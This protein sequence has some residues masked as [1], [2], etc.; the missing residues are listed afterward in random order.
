MPELPEVEIVRRTLSPLLGQRMM[1]VSVSGP[2]VIRGL[3]AEAF[4]AQLVGRQVDS[5]ERRGK[6]LLIGLTPK[7][8]VLVHLRMTGRLRLADATAPLERHTHVRIALESGGELRYTDQ[9]RFGGFWVVGEGTVPEGFRT[10]GPE[11][12]SGDLAA[13]QVHQKLSRRS[14]P[15]KAALLDQRLIA[16]IGNIY[17]DESLFRARL[18]PATPAHTLSEADVG[19]LL[20]AVR[21]TL[22]SA[23]DHHGT[24]ISDFLD[25]RGEPGLNAQQLK[26]YGRQGLSCEGCGGVIEKIRIAGRGTHYCPSCQQPPRIRK[27]R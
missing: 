16:G 10:L 1:A 22:A 20:T 11:P 24:T 26:V 18:H 25:G 9:R 19:R 21:Q 23:I 14:G 13:G 6:Y 12:L 5:L 7:A 17:A 8:T 3:S 2:D 15:I 4:A 27:V